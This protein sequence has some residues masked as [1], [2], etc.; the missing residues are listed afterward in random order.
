MAFQHISAQHILQA[1]TR[2]LVTRAEWDWPVTLA[3]NCFPADPS[4]YR[5]DKVWVEDFAHKMRRQPAYTGTGGTSSKI[6]YLMKG[7]LE[8]AIPVNKYELINTAE[9]DSNADPAIQPRIRR[10]DNALIKAKIE[11]E[12]RCARVLQDPSI[13]TQNKM[14][15]AGTRWDDILSPNSDPIGDLRTACR[16]INE[17]TGLTVDQIIIPQA[18]YLQMCKHRRIQDEAVSKLNLTADRLTI[19]N[20]IIER[21]LDDDLI[22]PGAVKQ[23]KAWF[24]NSADGPSS[25]S[26]NNRTYPMG[27]IVVVTASAKPGGTGGR[28][29]GFGLLKWWDVVREALPDAK[30]LEIAVGNEGFAV[31]SFPYMEGMGGDKQYFI[32]AGA[33]FVQN[34]D[35]AFVFYDAF[36]AADTTNYGTLFEPY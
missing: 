33:P 3:K 12:I 34:A 31:T 25:T 21:L 32:D 10:L 9:E 8:W 30:N 7:T 2:Y 5:A 17:I 22:Q 13:M 36:N 15:G 11:R 26:V 4:Q 28:D 19:N 20:H 35:A 16:F 27:N 6:N 23:Y 14:L 18:G 1:D 24:N 29:F